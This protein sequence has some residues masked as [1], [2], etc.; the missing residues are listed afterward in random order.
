M[1]FTGDIHQIDT[2]YL[3]EHSNGLS[4]LIDRVKGN[5]IYAHMT[6]EKGERSDLANLA[7]DLL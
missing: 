5:K 7:N 2:P 3:D 4:Y 1:I 6:L